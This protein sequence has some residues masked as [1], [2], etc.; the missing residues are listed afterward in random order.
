MT[1]SVDGVQLPLV[2]VQRKVAVEPTINPVIPEVAE[3]GV[4]IVA[5]PETTVQEPVPTEG[6]FAAKVAVVTQAAKVWSVPALAV[7][8]NELTVVAKVREVPLPHPFDG[9]TWIVPEVPFVVTVTELV[10][11]PPVCVQPEG[12]VHV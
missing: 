10:V 3:D 9:V 1:S 11:P 2:I 4:V 6:M 12:K 8:G 5:V 7:V